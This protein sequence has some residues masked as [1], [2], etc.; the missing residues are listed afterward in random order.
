M[1]LHGLV[2]RDGV[3]GRSQRM[4]F[5]EDISP[6]EFCTEKVSGTGRRGT[7]ACVRVWSVS[8]VSWLDLE[9]T[10]ACGEA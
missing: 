1:L 7:D 9:M 4:R 2:V 3:G 6:K 5:E 10:N 8:G